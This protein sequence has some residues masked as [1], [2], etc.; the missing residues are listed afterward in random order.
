LPKAVSTAQQTSQQ[1]SQCFTHV[2]DFRHAVATNIIDN[3]IPT[4]SGDSHIC[5]THQQHQHH[6]THRPY[7]SIDEPIERRDFDDEYLDDDDH[8]HG[9][10]SQYSVGRADLGP[11]PDTAAIGQPSPLLDVRHPHASGRGMHSDDHSMLVGPSHP[12]FGHRSPNHG[13]AGGLHDPLY[14][15]SVIVSAIV[16]VTD[17]G[18]CITSRGMPPPGA[19]FDPFGPGVA[20]PFG[21]GTGNR[22]GQF[23]YVLQVPLAQLVMAVAAT[24]IRC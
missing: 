22:R 1:L 19:R 7:N 18:Y 15:V 13:G 20:D 8:H 3:L 4:A 5:N 17:V 23:G 12:M 11:T 2:N 24:V 9:H 14:V 10:A 16:Q 21:G 6:A